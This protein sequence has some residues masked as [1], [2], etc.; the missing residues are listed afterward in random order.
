VHLASAVRAGGTVAAVPLAVSHGDRGERVSIASGHGS[1]SATRY[2]FRRDGDYWS[3]SYDSDPVPLRDRRG[4]AYIAQ[5]LRRQ[6]E[7]QHVLDLIFAVRESD[8]GVSAAL[9]GDKAVRLEDCR[10][11]DAGVVCDAQA[12][13]AYRRRLAD[14][15]AEISEAQAA[16]DLGR[17]PRLQFE[18]ERLAAELAAAF[19]IDGR[20]RRVGSAVERARINVRNSIVTARR[21]LDA[22]APRLG[23]HLEVSIRTGVYCSYRPERA[24]PW[25]L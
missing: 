18:R 2:L 7:E 22:R 9:G 5:L 17:I 15:D 13:D 6:G 8:R 21:V 24:T 11:G 3:V 19:G 23:K 10:W 25:T 16:N 14:L 12:R 1:P 20:P 4:F